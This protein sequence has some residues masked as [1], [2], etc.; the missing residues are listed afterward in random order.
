MNCKQF[1]TEDPVDWV[2]CEDGA[3][4]RRAE[5]GGMDS[6]GQLVYVGRVRYAGG[7]LPGQ[8]VPS[9]RMCYF[10]YDGQEHALRKY[11]A[12]VKKKCYVLKWTSASYGNIPRDSIKAGTNSIPLY[13]ARIFMEDGTAAIGTVLKHFA[14]SMSIENFKKLFFFNFQVYPGRELCYV[15][16]AGQEICRDKYE[17]LSVD[18][19]IIDRSYKKYNMR[20]KCQ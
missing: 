1:F 19:F 6:N 2:D 14:N 3:V 17:I 12:L 10:S 8:I 4:P 13:I 15:A 5:I 7:W 18:E 11:Q 20:K 16:C 9:D